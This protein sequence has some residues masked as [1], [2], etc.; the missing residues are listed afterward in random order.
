[1]TYSNKFFDN[2]GYKS[3]EWDPND[4]YANNYV[5]LAKNAIVSRATAATASIGRRAWQPQNQSITSKL[6][7]NLLKP[8]T[9]K[10]LIYDPIIATYLK[11]DTNNEM[12]AED[13]NMSGFR[14]ELGSTIL[15][16]NSE[17]TRIAVSKSIPKRRRIEI[18]I[19]R[20]QT[21][22]RNIIIREYAGLVEH[23][24]GLI[25]ERKSAD[26]PVRPNDGS[27][28]ILVKHTWAINRNQMGDSRE[29]HIP[30]TPAEMMNETPRQM[31]SMFF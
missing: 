31:G 11:A 13:L 7:R 28:T 30:K 10:D 17:Y 15:E 3:G 9:F 6:V 1:M 20:M 22:L 27:T 19:G 12:S 2:A 4:T 18:L 21:V 26:L 14:L 16:D 8:E 23:K 24:R 29:S 25:F 5:V